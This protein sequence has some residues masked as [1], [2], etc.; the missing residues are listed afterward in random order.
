MSDFLKPTSEK[1][2]IS[3]ILTLITL[4]IINFFPTEIRCGTFG[5]PKYISSISEIPPNVEC[6]YKYGFP[7]TSSYKNQI[8]KTTSGG[9]I[10]GF[11][12]NIV[13]WFIV[14]YIVSIPI[15]SLFNKFKKSKK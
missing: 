1:I 2:V 4:F 10:G 11:L 13:I 7:F 6:N 14:A 15:S 5:E 12:L 3:I 9:I 8:G